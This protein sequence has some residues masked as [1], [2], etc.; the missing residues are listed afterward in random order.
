LIRDFPFYPK[1]QV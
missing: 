1:S